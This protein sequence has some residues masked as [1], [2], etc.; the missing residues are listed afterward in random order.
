M[1]I[2]FIHGLESTP[3][4]SSTGKAIAAA[5]P[6]VTLADYKPR[7][8]SFNEIKQYLAEISK[9]MDV[10]IGI[11]LG[12][13]WTLKLTEFTDINNVVMINPAFKKAESIYGRKVYPPSGVLGKMLLN[14]DD[15][16]VDNQENFEKY[17]N[18]FSI[19]TYETGG[20]RASNIQDMIKDIKESM[21]LFEN[22]IPISE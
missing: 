7:Q 12:G 21:G 15:N 11:S 18:R 19:T 10:V 17:H 1:N 13:Y 9:G 8:N 6:N 4:T 16:V 5:F 14:M 22:W 20:H 2:L 3:E